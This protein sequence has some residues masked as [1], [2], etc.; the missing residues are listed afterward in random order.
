MPELTKMVKDNAP[1][2][3]RKALMM[4][5]RLGLPILTARLPVQRIKERWALYEQGLI[6]GGHD[7]AKRARLFAREPVPFL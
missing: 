7:P 6:E 3:R 1:L 5:G 2:Q 4:L